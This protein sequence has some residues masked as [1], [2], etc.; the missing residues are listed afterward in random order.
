MRKFVVIL[1][2]AL[3]A[4]PFL[5]QKSQALGLEVA[6]GV[7]SQGPSGDISYDGN[8][9]PGTTL[10]IEKDLKYDKKTKLFG[11]IKAELPLFFPNIYIMATPMKFEETGSK[12][13]PFTFGN[14]T[15]NANV[16]FHSKLQ[17][18]HYD[19]AFYYSL[20]FLK[21][22][23]MGKLNAELGINAR[24]ID[25]KAEITQ[26][27]LGISESQSFT[28]PVPMIY[29]G[30][31]VNPVKFFSVELEGRGIAYSSNHYYDFIGRVKIRPFGPIFVAGGYRIEDIKIDHSDIKASIKFKGP[32]AEAGVQ[33]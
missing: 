14:Q 21:T 6:A 18:D 30:I 5:P 10:D 28:I 32:F 24:I 16:P 25:L 20:P 33:F 27:T 29:A 7:W 11:R 17:L 13:I 23:T 4:I 3:F 19:I 26:N 2:I 1:A 12:N 15:F 8:L 31:Q 9:A 22:A